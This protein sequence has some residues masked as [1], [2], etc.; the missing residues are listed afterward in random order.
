L[1]QSGFPVSSPPHLAVVMARQPLDIT[2][3]TNSRELIERPK[4]RPPCGLTARMRGLFVSHL[5][6]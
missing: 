6:W 4:D 2:F 1:N 5:N 3:R